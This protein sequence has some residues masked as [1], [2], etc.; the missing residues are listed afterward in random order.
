MATL[1]SVAIISLITDRRLIQLNG[2]NPKVVIVDFKGVQG[3]PFKHNTAQNLVDE[4]KHTKLVRVTCDHSTSDKSSTAFHAILET[5]SIPLQ[6]SVKNDITLPLSL[7]VLSFA[8]LPAIYGHLKVT[9][10]VNYHGEDCVQDQPPNRGFMVEHMPILLVFV[11][12]SLS[13]P[14]NQMQEMDRVFVNEI[15]FVTWGHEFSLKLESNSKT[16]IENTEFGGRG[17]G[18]EDVQLAPAPISS[19]PGSKLLN[20]CCSLPVACLEL[21]FVIFFLTLHIFDFTTNHSHTHDHLEIPDSDPSIDSTTV[22]DS[23]SHKVDITS[24][25]TAR[26]TTSVKTKSSQRRKGP[27]QTL[28]TFVTYD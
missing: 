3:L 28:K 15:I 12:T 20:V 18:G 9:A 10:A 4:V 27:E 22:S 14:M 19:F 17:E 24:S 1:S 8:Y 7:S 21:L 25:A 16:M 6:T 11:V 2:S 23:V 13:Y 5:R 26:S